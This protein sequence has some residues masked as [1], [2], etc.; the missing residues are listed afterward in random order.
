MAEAKTYC[1]EAAALVGGDRAVQHGDKL[2]N[3]QNIAALWTA[4]LYRRGLISEVSELSAHD[5]AVM[6]VLLKVARTLTGAHNPDDYRDGV[7]YLAIAGS[8]ADIAHE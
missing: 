7:G 6:M 4:W 8:L 1:E 2:I 5:A 3:H